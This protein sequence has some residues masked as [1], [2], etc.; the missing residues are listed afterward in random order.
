[1]QVERAIQ[2]NI[3]HNYQYKTNVHVLVFSLHIIL[4]DLLFVF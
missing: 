2:G 3:L 4:H 1:M